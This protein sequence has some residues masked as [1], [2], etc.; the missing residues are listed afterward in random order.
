MT[1]AEAIRRLESMATDLT[2]ACV[3]AQSDKVSEYIARKIQAVDMAIAALK[4]QDVTDKNVGNKWISVEARLPEIITTTETGN[5]TYKRSIRVLCACK[6]ASGKRMVKEGFAE[7]LNDC[8]DPNWK[9]PGTIDCVTHW[10]PLPE[11]PK[12]V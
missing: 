5:I 8:P 11:P 2:G 1:R 6:Q 3:E 7:F 12:E 10:M 4:E 9:I